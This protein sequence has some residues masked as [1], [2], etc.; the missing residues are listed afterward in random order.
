MLYPFITIGLIAVF[1]VYIF[2]FLLI[3]RDIE[4]VKAG[5][6]PGIFFIIIWI[7]IYYFLLK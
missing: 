1:A 2:Y 3:R 6:Y 7:G 4:K 5:L